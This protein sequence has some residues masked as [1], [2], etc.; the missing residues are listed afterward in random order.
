MDDLGDRRDAIRESRQEGLPR[1]TAGRLLVVDDDPEV[2]A[3]LVRLLAGRGYDVEAVGDVVAASRALGSTITRPDLVLLDLALPGANGLELLSAIRGDEATRELPTLVV[4]GAM[5][6]DYAAVC[7]ERGADDYIVKPIDSRELLARVDQQLRRARER[8][9]WRA[10]SSTDLLTG[11]PNRRAFV[12]RLEQELHRAVR[13]RC[14]LAVAFIDVDGFKLFNDQWGH[15]AGDR[16]LRLVAEGLTR[17]LRR[18]DV[19][20][21]WGGDEFVA[22]LP[23]AD[24]RAAEDALERVRD[25]VAARSREVLP[26]TIQFSIG[27]RCLE[28]DAV[29]S[30]VHTATRLVNESDRAM[31]ADKRRRARQR[32]LADGTPTKVRTEEGSDR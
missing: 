13:D 19:A 4:S 21:R 2:R 6:R 25:S 26:R 5:R 14:S 30:D 32:R 10:R 29:V 1:G 7:L 11:L 28:A 31:Y 15:A 22:V 23:G 8:H 20:A 18:C 24:H 3:F 12:E 9:E 16:V 27:V 17:T